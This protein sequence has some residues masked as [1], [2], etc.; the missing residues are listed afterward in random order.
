MIEFIFGI[1]FILVVV[2]ILQDIASIAGT[3]TELI[4]YQLAEKIH[5]IQERIG[6]LDDEEDNKNPI[7]FQTDL[8]GVPL[9]DDSN[10]DE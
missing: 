5:K 4:T 6:E 8:I 2:P 1:V 9:D 10:E 7:G 3:V